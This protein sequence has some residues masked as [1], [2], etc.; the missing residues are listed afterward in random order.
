MPYS[1]S[2]LLSQM[3]PAPVCTQAVNAGVPQADRL[4]NGQNAMT[5]TWRYDCLCMDTFHHSL[6]HHDLSAQVTMGLLEPCLLLKLHFLLHMTVLPILSHVAIPSAYRGQH[7]EHP[8]HRCAQ[9]HV[10]GQAGRRK[11]QQQCPLWTWHQ[12]P[13]QSEAAG[14]AGSPAPS[15]C[16]LSGRQCQHWDAGQRLQ[17]GPM[18]A[19]SRCSPADRHLPLS[20][21]DKAQHRLA[22]A[23]AKLVE[24]TWQ[25]SSAWCT[26]LS[27]SCTS[28][29]T[30]GRCEW[31]SAMC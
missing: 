26:A 8:A 2:L 11:W 9:G 24:L 5:M 29:F 22:S 17:P 27:G 12:P 30:L 20:Q 23:A 21:P 19:V 14:T 15:S 18:L 31:Y 7:Q 4:C 16:P 28:V 3:V 25:E 10:P 6:E 1:S 13:E